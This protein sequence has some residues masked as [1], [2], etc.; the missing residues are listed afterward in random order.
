MGP[1]EEEGGVGANSAEATERGG[2]VG[3]VSEEVWTA[4]ARGSV[5]ADDLG[6]AE[7]LP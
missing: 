7:D 4:L 3:L 1:E 5:A 6:C 2:E